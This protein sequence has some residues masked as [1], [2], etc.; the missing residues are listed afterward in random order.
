LIEHENSSQCKYN[1]GTSKLLKHQV[2]F[3]GPK[4]HRRFIL[5][6]F[7]LAML[8][9]P[10]LAHA[11][12]VTVTSK[13]ISFADGDSPTTLTADF[14]NDG[15]EDLVSIT[16]NI[17]AGQF[18]LRLSTGDGAYGPRVIYDLPGFTTEYPSPLYALAIGDFNN[19]GSADI[20]VSSAAPGSGTP[21][22]E[23][24]IYTNNGH[25]A[26]TLSTTIPLP[27]TAGATAFT[28]GDFNHDR[29][30]D[31][32]YVS[33]GQLHILF[34]NGK[35]GFT[36]G[37]VTGTTNAGEPLM[38]GDFDGDGNADLAYGEYV[39]N[40]TNATVLFGDG[41]G[42]F[43]PKTVVSPENVIFTSGDVNSDGR[44]DLI[45]TPSFKNHMDVFYGNTERTFANTTKIFFNQCLDQSPT[46]ADMDGNGL[47]DILTVERNCSDTTSGFDAN[48]Y[49]GVRTRNGNASYNPE[50][51]LYH[52]TSNQSIGGI[53]FGP[54]VMRLNQDSKP[55]FAFGLCADDR[56]LGTTMILEQNT[57]SGSFPACP[58]PNSFEGIH[59]CSPANGVASPV[60]FH[61]GAAGQTEMRKVEVWIDGV[62]KVEELDGFSH[63]SFLDKTIQMTP[64][65]HRVTI[66]AAGIDNLLQ[67]KTYTLTVQ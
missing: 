51:T 44:T 58:A 39:A 11:A 22:F 17:G 41:T 12:A 59:V 36:A 66:F 9:L 33:N 15:R 25:G 23:V 56:C 26:L 27:V 38:L 63:C 5:N 64:G 37:P 30:I 35:N 13:S 54:M 4:M 3:R 43:I 1:L 19:D 57:T 67:Q 14:N 52:T 42:H 60:P 32:A 31:I 10:C 40:N 34:G 21:K 18:S 7:V 50:Q 65:N 6:A 47:K 20:A 28:A 62:K 24:Y 61:I 8:S 45:G 53:L 55:D 16:P 2:S 46:L 49:V 48:Y 29:L